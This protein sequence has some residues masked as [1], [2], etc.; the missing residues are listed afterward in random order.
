MGKIKDWIKDHQAL[1]IGCL[2]LVIML[3]GCSSCSSE[4]RYEYNISQYEQQ[5]DSMQNIINTWSTDSKD[6][7][8][9]IHSLRAENTV[10]K[11]VIKDIK[12]DKEY[13]RKQNKNLTS[14]AENLSKYEK[15]DTLK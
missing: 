8:D 12:A 11:E 14:V 9:T 4:R 7:Y 1:I 5:I 6:L 15:H 2:L 3:K 10:L 13:Y